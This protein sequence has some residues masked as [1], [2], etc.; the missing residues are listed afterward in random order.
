[1]KAT[2][3]DLRYRTKEILRALDRREK[4]TLL[5]HGKVKGEILPAGSEMASKIKVQDHP[6]FGM[7]EQDAVSVEDVVESLRRV[8]TDAL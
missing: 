6:F 3:V 5:Y 7:T 1:M 4:V 2:V 8:R